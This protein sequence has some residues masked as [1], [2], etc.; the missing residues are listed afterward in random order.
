VIRPGA[1]H[2][3]RH[4]GRGRQKE[5]QSFTEALGACLS[6]FLGEADQ[7]ATKVVVNNAAEREL[8]GWVTLEILDHEGSD[9]DL[10]Q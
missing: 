4:R 9:R 2:H 6:R 8:S 10:N 3:A 1:R 7:A 5:A